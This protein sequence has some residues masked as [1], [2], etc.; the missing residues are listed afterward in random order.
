V[1][2][3]LVELL[4]SQWSYFHFNH[5]ERGVK[6]HS[7]L[8]DRIAERYAETYCDWIMNYRSAYSTISFEIR[9]TCCKVNFG[10]FA[11]PNLDIVDNIW[12]SMYRLLL[13]VMIEISAFRCMLQLIQI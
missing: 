6:L 9:P 12:L 11:D 8:V 4:V 3:R 2:E 13:M 7:R 5:K 1:F 10:I